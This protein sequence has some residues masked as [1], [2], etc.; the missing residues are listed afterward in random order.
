MTPKPKVGDKII[1]EMESPNPDTSRH[2]K[3]F[4]VTKV[5]PCFDPADQFFAD[6]IDSGFIIRADE[7]EIKF[8]LGSKC[9]LCRK[10][11]KKDFWKMAKHMQ[12][13][14]LKEVSV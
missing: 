6:V 11:F 2:F 14:H 1:C 3:I 12:D 5:K 8:E 7:K 13:K 10:R 4:N 9:P